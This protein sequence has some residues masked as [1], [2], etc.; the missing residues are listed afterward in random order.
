MSAPDVADINFGDE[1]GNGDF[2]LEVEPVEEIDQAIVPSMF[3][4]EWHDYVMSQFIDEE[5]INNQPTVDGLRRVAQDILGPI[6]DQK[7]KVFTDGDDRATAIFKVIFDS[8]GTIRSF[9]GAANCIPKNM[10]ENKYGIFAVAIAETRAEGR[11]YRKALGIR[12]IAAEE[13]A[14]V[15]LQES[16][17]TKNQ[18]ST[19]QML[20]SKIGL[21]S[22]KFIGD[23]Y[24]GVLEKCS[25]ETATSMLMALSSYRGGKI[26]IP[27][28]LKV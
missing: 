24:Q 27:E 26:Q 25:Y 1:N 2:K 6:V 21:D 17:I 3:S 7:V 15:T 9:V 8:I 4:P 22:E 11:A 16:F 14:D 18:I 5:L 10:S 12:S 20:C 23:N 13:A 19:I 28:R